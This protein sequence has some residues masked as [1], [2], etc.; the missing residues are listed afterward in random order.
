MKNRTR[1]TETRIDA[2]MDAQAPLG[3]LRTKHDPWERGA[4]AQ[5]YRLVA[6]GRNEAA[7]DVLGELILA[8]R[9]ENRCHDAAHEAA[10]ELTGALS[11]A[12]LRASA[13]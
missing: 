7:L 5:V 6:D 1:A 2:G 3:D 8:D 4:L 11:D 10:R 9:R 13:G 12:G